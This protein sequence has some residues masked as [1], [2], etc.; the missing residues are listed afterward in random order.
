M[1]RWIALVVVVVQAAC[2]PREEGMTAG[3]GRT[4]GQV[5]T[6]QPAV[7]VNEAAGGA[8]D[9][10]SPQLSS[11]G[12]EG[13]SGTW[14]TVERGYDQWTITFP[15]DAPSFRGTGEY[16]NDIT[17]VGFVF[18]GSRELNRLTLTLESPI[19]PEVPLVRI[20]GSIEQHEIRASFFVPDV[21]EPVYTR[22]FARR[23]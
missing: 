20:E 7:P 17:K 10:Q 6:G 16:E 8:I 2:G 18:S 1:S 9:S 13:A 12:A 22:V 21:P 5:D 14:V 23:P 19:P 11:D 3:T 4:A 15:N